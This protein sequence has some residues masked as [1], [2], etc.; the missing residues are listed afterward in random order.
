MN[1]TETKPTSFSELDRQNT[2]NEKKR[3]FEQFK[4]EKYPRDLFKRKTSKDFLRVVYIYSTCKN[5]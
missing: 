1:Q 2:Y 3:N 4:S 5:I